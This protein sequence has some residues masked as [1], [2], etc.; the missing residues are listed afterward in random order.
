MVWYG[1]LALSLVQ[2]MTGD[3]FLLFC[4]NLF[5]TLR[6]AQGAMKLSILTLIGITVGEDEV[7]AWE[8]SFWDKYWF[9]SVEASQKVNNPFEDNGLLGNSCQKLRFNFDD[10]SGCFLPVNNCDMRLRGQVHHKIFP[11]SN[12]TITRPCHEQLDLKCIY[13]LVLTLQTWISDWAPCSVLLR[14]YSGKTE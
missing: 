12:C 8:V 13:K 10:M 11:T 14:F 4:R 7:A 6:S 9:V 5:T 1:L 3:I 2:V